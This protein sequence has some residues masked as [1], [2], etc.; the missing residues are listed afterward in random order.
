MLTSLYCICVKHLF[1]IDAVGVMLYVIKLCTGV[2][3]FCDMY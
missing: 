2:T 3:H 1:Y